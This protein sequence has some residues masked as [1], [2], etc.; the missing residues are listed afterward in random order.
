MT[1]PVPATGEFDVAI[2]GGGAAGVLVAIHLLASEGPA[3]RIAVIEPRPVLGQGAAYSTDQ[4]E[5]LL[6]VIASRMSAF[7]ADPSHFVRYL[8]TQPDYRGDPLL[9]QRFAQRRDYGRYLQATLAAMPGSDNVHWLRD[10]AVDI[11]RGEVSMI[12]L[13][14]DVSVHACAVVLALG[15][16]ARGLPLPA[17]ALH[18][19]T[20]AIDAWDYRAIQRIE[21]SAEVGILG[22]GLSMVDAVV[23]LA[24]RGHRGRIT[25][26]SRHGLVPLS[27][28]RPGTQDTDIGDLPQL[29]LRQRL[30]AIRRLAAE[31][32]RNGE[33]WQWTMDRLRHHVQALWT[34][35]SPVE[36]R[37][38][39]RHGA[40]FWDIHR[41]R[42]APSVA[43]QLDA[44]QVFGQLRV[45]A[46]HLVSIARDS[47][48]TRIHFRPR[49][50]SEA[51]ELRVDHLIN[52]TGMESNIARMASPLVA[53]LRQQGLIAS[54]PHGIGLATDAS[55]KIV[56]EA[57]A[58][59][60]LATLGAMRI[61]MLWE[62]IAI[63]E[64]R[65]QARHLAIA[66][67]SH[68]RV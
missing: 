1:H 9:A 60:F 6:N 68:L 2:I 59:V 21:P 44:L 56:T 5:H 64:L 30:R 43:R 42:I 38:F 41:H 47:E 58:Q 7:P 63:P 45:L 15:N 57:A 28:A 62:S 65:E 11:D 17:S 67:R 4:P 48:G 34:S 31:A 61:G 37:R 51:Q 40:R 55:G 8:E 19:S 12:R 46:G 52:S 25:V 53:S 3:L 23:S 50:E 24:A 14:S 26:I 35:L 13:A 16:F 49:G 32:Q 29:G 22:S 27:H 39:L 18:G 20:E 10:E 54:G 66:L 36:Q 33:P